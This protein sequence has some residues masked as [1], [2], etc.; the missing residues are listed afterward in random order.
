MRNIFDQAPDALN[1]Y[2]FRDV[3]NLY[4][5]KELKSHYTKLITALD[6]VIQTLSSPKDISKNLKSLGKRHVKYG[7]IKEHYNIIGRSLLM[8]LDEGL[9]EDF[10]P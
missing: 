1:L 10:T 8:T 2:S 7:V 6:G 9:N 5:S 4:T 3:P